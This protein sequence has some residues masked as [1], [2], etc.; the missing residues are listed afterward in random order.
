MHKQHTQQTH[1]QQTQHNHRDNICKVKA[2]LYLINNLQITMI[3]W[4]KL[5][6]AREVGARHSAFKSKVKAMRLELAGQ[7]GAAAAVHSGAC[8]RS[9]RLA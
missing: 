5:S 2:P 4:Q 7:H 8:M 3:V 6:S 1:T 9:Q